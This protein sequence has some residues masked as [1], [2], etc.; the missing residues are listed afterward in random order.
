MRHLLPLLLLAATLAAEDQPRQLDPSQPRDAL[1]VVDVLTADVQM[2]RRQAE[3]FRT[4]LLTLA[5]VVEEREAAEAAANPPQP[6][7]KK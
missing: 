3:A 1:A 5:R 2:S 7:E 6:P 4:A